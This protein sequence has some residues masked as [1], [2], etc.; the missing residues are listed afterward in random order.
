MNLINFFITEVNINTLLLLHEKTKPKDLGLIT[1]L[2]KKNP[3]II[4]IKKS[5]LEKGRDK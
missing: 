2:I 5:Q 4:M 1:R 3:P